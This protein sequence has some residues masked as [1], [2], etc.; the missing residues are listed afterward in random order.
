MNANYLSFHLIGLD[1]I[2]CYYIIVKLSFR[3]PN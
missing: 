1:Q 2:N 3:N